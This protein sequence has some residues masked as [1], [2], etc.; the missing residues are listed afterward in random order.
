MKGSLVELLEAHQSRADEGFSEET[1]S[2][3]VAGEEL[4]FVLTRPTGVIHPVGVVL[5]PSYFELSML[6]SAEIEFARRSA[7]AG[8]A[9]LYI[10]PPGAGDSTG[11]PL[12][13]TFPDRVG[14]ALAG[15][16][17]LSR[18]VE[19]TERTCFFG[20]RAGGLVAL[21]AA[22][23]K[24]G[25]CAIAWDP[26]LD[27]DLY[28]SQVRRLAR[29][30]AVVGRQDMFEEPQAEVSR[31]GRSSIMGIDIT[32]EQLE[33]LRAAP[34]SLRPGSIEGPVLVVGLRDPL[35]ES[36]VATLRPIVRG[37]IEGLSLGRR[38][39]WHLGLRRGAEVIEPTIEWMS[40]SLV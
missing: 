12:A 35:V 20:P 37:E 22:G 10:Q 19:G 30:A 2:L 13:C 18:R 5:S 14:A 16:A 11:D 29:V 6:Q 17:E 23:E 34:G 9:C 4:L 27:G 3:A 28:W 7:R 38:D 39:I 15:A 24:P 33:D 1:G 31:D 8:F 32:P 25:S 40:R 21:L 36:A 26:A